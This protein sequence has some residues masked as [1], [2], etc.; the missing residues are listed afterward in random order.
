M[1]TDKN[2]SVYPVQSQKLDLSAIEAVFLDVDQT[3]LDFD[4]CAR[5][6]LEMA[7]LLAG[8]EYDERYFASFLHL[9]A[10]LW[11]RI[12]EGSLNRAEFLKLRFPFMF[13]QWK[14]PL[15]DPEQ[16]EQNFSVMLHNGA[17]T[18]PGAREGVALLQKLNLPLFIISNGPCEGQKNRLRKAGLLE[19]FQEV[20][21]SQDLGV[22]KPERAFFEQ[23]A[24][25]SEKRLGRS[26]NPANILVIGDSYKADIQGAMNMGMP[27]VWIRANRQHDPFVAAPDASVFPVLSWEQLNTL[28]EAALSERQNGS[29]PVR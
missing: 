29:I 11:D 22:S 7:F 8:L 28:L 27:S 15:N 18:M 26:L 10:L 21:T 5:A 9:N 14:L 4:A 24:A 16:F 19:C 20:Y 6:A 25:A 3:L 1:L 12:E 13:S 17:F 23:A 2:H